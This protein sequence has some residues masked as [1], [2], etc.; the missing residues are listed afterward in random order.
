MLT[1]VLPLRRPLVFLDL[2]TTGIA[3]DCD[4]IVEI[5][6][7][8]VHPDGREHENVFRVNPGV[9][10]PLGA[11]RVHGISDRDVA[12][13]P[14]FAAL[15]RTL[16]VLLAGCDLAGFNITSYDLPLLEAEFGRCGLPFSRDGRAIVD[17]MTLFR[18]KETLQRRDLSAAVQHYCGRDHIGAHSALADVRATA[19]VLHHQLLRYVDLPRDVGEL[20]AY[21]LGAKPDHFVDPE[22]RLRQRGGEI[23]LGFGKHFGVALETLAREEPDYLRWMLSER[24]SPLVKAEVQ[25][26]LQRHAPT[27]SPVTAPP[28]RASRRRRW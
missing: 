20:H 18:R 11:W 1:E 4:R 8:T 23:V 24:F 28:P 2:E 21:C 10:I 6:L 9:P 5:A 16:S 22:G 15:A 12:D 13:R 7:L 14:P 25:A 3:V 19:E 27:H 26:A 17:V